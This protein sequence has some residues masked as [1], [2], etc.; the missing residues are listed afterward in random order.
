L[1]AELGTDWARHAEGSRERFQRVVT[2][3]QEQ[4]E[5]PQHFARRVRAK[6][7]E[8]GSITAATLLCS[9]S[10]V[11]G[12]IAGR[13]SILEGCL[14]TLAGVPR[15]ELSLILTS[16]GRAI[17]QWLETLAAGVEAS[18][19]ALELTVEFDGESVAA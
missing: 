17:P 8:L 10:G 19:P 7:A 11:R 9:D 16:H 13:R 5:L 3:L 6:L 2:L 15:R 12:S 18:D 1:V 14:A 4:G